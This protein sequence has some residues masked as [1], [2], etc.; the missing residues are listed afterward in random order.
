MRLTHLL[1]IAALLCAGETFA[2]TTSSQNPSSDISAPPLSSGNQASADQFRIS[3]HP[4]S[5][6][7]SQSAASNDPMDRIRVDQF[8]PNPPARNRLVHRGAYYDAGVS[9]YRIR[10][11]RVVR[12][13]RDSDAT[14]ID[15]YST[16]VRAENLRV[17][18][19][20]DRQTN[21]FPTNDLWTNDLW[22]DDL[23]TDDLRTDDLRTDDR[24]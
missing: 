19:T 9:C 12:D 6:F 1:A 5:D 17:Y 15:G 3:P 13:S 16:C 23:R 10:S 24:R 4:Q 14:H 18:R 21:D 7:A 2:Q 11:Y 20:K 22:T 8:D